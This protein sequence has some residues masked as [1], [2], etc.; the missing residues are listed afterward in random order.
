MLP[1][2]N[3]SFSLSKKKKTKTGRP[4]QVQISWKQPERY[5]SAKKVELALIKQELISASKDRLVSVL[6]I[7]R[8]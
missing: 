4:I 7:I 8:L 3:S 2:I 6:P 5:L 1:L